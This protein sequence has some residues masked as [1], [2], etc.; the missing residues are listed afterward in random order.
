[1]PFLYYLIAAI[2]LVAAM[3]P[4]MVKNA[5]KKEEPDSDSDSD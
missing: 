1:M 2:G 5:V 3:K 4:E